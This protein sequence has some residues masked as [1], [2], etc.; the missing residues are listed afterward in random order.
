MQKNPEG[1]RGMKLM[2]KGLKTKSP[3]QTL[4][5]AGEISVCILLFYSPGSPR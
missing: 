1:G 5:S 2:N 4:R 3:R